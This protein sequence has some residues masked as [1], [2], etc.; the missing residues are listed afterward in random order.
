VFAILN[1]L[2]INYSKKDLI[3]ISVEI[4]KGFLDKKDLFYNQYLNNLLE[5][6]LLLN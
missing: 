2:I 6:E 1:D 5:L 3:I 4:L